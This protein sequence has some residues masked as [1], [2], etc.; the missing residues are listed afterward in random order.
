M[1]RL[2]YTPEEA[3]GLLGLGRSK[4]YELLSAGAIRSIRVGR[5]RRIPAEAL[6]EWIEKRAQLDEECAQEGGHG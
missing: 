3:A 4:T 5:L 1:E 6:R 2:L